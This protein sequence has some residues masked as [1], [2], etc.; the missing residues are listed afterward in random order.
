M[1]TFV[2]FIKQTLTEQLLHARHCAQL[3]KHNDDEAGVLVLK[4]V[5][6]RRGNTSRCSKHLQ[7]TMALNN[8]V[9]FLT[10]QG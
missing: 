3:S 2:T 8:K 4:S 9:L 10:V 6:V 5:L 1:T 7:I